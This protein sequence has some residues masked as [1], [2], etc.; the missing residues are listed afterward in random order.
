MEPTVPMTKIGPDVVQ[1]TDIFFASISLIKFF[2]YRSSII[3]API[4]Y[5][6][7]MLIIKAY[8]DTPGVPNNFLEIGSNF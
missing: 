2:E 3:F 6:D 8:K 7:K 4:G 5:P 1:N